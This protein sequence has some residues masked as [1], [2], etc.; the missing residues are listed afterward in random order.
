MEF[1]RLEIP[2]RLLAPAEL[3]TSGQTPTMFLSRFRSMLVM[4]LLAAVTG[5]K[6]RA[7]AATFDIVTSTVSADA[8]AA[9]D[10]A[11]AIWSDHLIST[12]AIKVRIAFLPV[13]PGSFLGTTVPNGE[14]N[15]SGAPVAD[16]WYPSC[17]ANALAN[18]ELN[19]GERDMDIFVPSTEDWYYGTDG[20]PGPGQFDFVSLILHEIGHG[21]G[22]LSLAKVEGDGSFGEIDETDIPFLPSFGL[23]DLEGSPSIFDYYLEDQSGTSLQDPSLYP[24]PGPE[25]A[26]GFTSNQLYFNGLN[27]IDA[28]LGELP[29]IYA[30]SFFDPGS[31]VTHV[32]EVT[33]NGTDNDL[34]TPFLSAAEV[35]HIPG[36]IVLGILRDIGWPINNETVLAETL[37]SNHQLNAWPNP[38][39]DFCKVKSSEV[40]SVVQIQDLSGRVVLLAEGN[41]AELIIDLST[42]PE[43]YHLLSETT[44]KQTRIIRLLINR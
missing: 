21:L 31:S 3:L 32:N 44:S 17:L 30:P 16:V 1:G 15:F 27:A 42:L 41:G 29:R 28:N 8:S 22:V 20:N 10:Y 12:Q 9:I 33:Y 36:P 26:N 34:M 38:A 11:A 4:V 39:A 5:Q 14:K 7:Q 24:N 43:G 18:T 35:N 23:P 19:P 13:P 2:I 40:G 37:Q 6:V 25:L